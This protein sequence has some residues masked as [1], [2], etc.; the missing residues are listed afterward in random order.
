MNVVDSD[1]FDCS[2]YTDY[3]GT[4]GSYDT[5]DFVANDAC[6]A[7]NG[8]GSNDDDRQDDNDSDI[9]EDCQD[10]TSVT[11]SY[12]D[13]CSWYN[14]NAGS[15]GT[16]D[17]SDFTANEAC[18]ACGGG[19]GNN[20]NSQD[21]NNDNNNNDGQPNTDGCSDDMTVTDSYGDTC[22]YY[23]SYPSGCGYFD[24]DDFV[25]TEACCA[26]AP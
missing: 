5:Q 7:C 17:D 24:D 16:F 19:D 14:T 12:G 2:W 4:C 6:C 18:C 11:D 26:C 21:D 3:P 20:D 13:G 8:G 1:G 25:S 15:C 10:D 22:S 9:Y 23:N